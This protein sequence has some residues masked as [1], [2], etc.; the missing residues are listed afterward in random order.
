MYGTG[1]N[2]IETTLKSLGY[3][4]TYIDTYYGTVTTAAVK[5]FQTNKGLTPTGA[6]D[7][8]TGTALGI[9]SSTTTSSSRILETRVIGYSVKGRP[10][11][12]YHLGTPGGTV[13]LAVGVLHGNE[14]RGIQIANYLK[15][16]ATIPSNVDLWII[17][18]ANPDGVYYGTRGNAHG[19]DLNRN[20]DTWD[21]RKVGVGTTKYSGPS[22]ASEPETKALQK[23]IDQI[24]PKVAVWWHQV[25]MYV[26]DNR[27]VGN[28]TLLRRYSSLTGYPIKYVSCVTACVGNATTYI[29]QTKSGATSFVVEMPS[30]YGS[31]T[32]ASHGKAFL[33]ISS[34]A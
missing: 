3:Q 20:F 4:S 26:D 27:T 23:F 32:I 17:P 7:Q 19:V 13:A 2:C 29:N 6:V 14:P 12:A 18:N 34:E 21:W 22:P 30:T 5:S 10:I 28:Y 24:R 16:S 25:G 11:T 31:T 33:R 1:V 8:A 15:N 9:W